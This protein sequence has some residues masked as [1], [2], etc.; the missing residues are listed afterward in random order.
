MDGQS[1]ADNILQMHSIGYE[2]LSHSAEKEMS[3]IITC[4][5]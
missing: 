3:G 2:V 5:L 4:I 1:M